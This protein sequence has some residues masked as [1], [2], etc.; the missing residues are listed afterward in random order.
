M[1]LRR[2]VARFFVLG[3]VLCLTSLV[4]GLWFAYLYFTDSE[5]ISRTIREHAA[6]Y[7]PRAIL[8]PG[9]VRPR[10]FAGEL[11]LHDL[12]LRQAIDGAVYET[13]RIP[14]LKLQVNPRKLAEGKFE[15][16]S[17]SVGQPTLRLRCR[18]DGTWNLEGLLAD[19]WPGPWIETPPIQIS[20]GTIELYPCEEP[21]SASDQP[22]ASTAARSPRPRCRRDRPRRKPRHRCPVVPS[23]TAPPFFA[24]SVSRSI[25]VARAKAISSSKARPAVTAL[26]E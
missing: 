16:S 2:R 20:H 18:K 15:P 8:D 17:I 21:P 12:K 14:F 1:C 23:I 19:P 4:G 9:R 22:P 13:L 5:T 25:P 24:T 26:S 10:V 6:R 3:L 11:V 7:L